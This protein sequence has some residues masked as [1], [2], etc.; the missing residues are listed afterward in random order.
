VLVRLN[1]N[2]VGL[3]PAAKTKGVFVTSK[4]IFVVDPS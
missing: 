1:G 3:P 2:R 4:R